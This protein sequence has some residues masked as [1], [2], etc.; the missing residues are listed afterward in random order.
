MLQ[1]FVVNFK[2]PAPPTQAAFF[3]FATEML[4]PCMWSTDSD[5]L[6]APYIPGNGLRSAT[7]SDCA[8][9]TTLQGFTIVS[10]PSLPC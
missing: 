4:N 3:F 8:V 1:V 6:Q 10:M 9:C 5:F 7:C 2:E